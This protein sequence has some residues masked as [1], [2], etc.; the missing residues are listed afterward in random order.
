MRRWYV[1]TAGLVA[2]VTSG[3][4]ALVI[5]ESISGN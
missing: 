1:V 5:T 3:Y 2:A 4:T